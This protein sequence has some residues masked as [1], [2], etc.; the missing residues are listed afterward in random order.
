LPGFEKAYMECLQQESDVNTILTRKEEIVADINRIVGT[1]DHNTQAQCRVLNAVFDLIGQIARAQHTFYLVRADTIK[2]YLRSGGQLPDLEYDKATGQ[3]TYQPAFEFTY[4]QPL[5]EIEL[6]VPIDSGKSFEE[7]IGGFLQILNALKGTEKAG[8][9]LHELTEATLIQRIRPRDANWRWFTDGFADFITHELLKKHLGAGAA[10]DWAGI[11]DIK[12]YDDLQ[13]EINLMYWMNIPYCVTPTLE[14]EQRFSH[15]RY[16]YAMHEAQRLIQAYGLDCVRKILDRVCSQKYQTAQDLFQA[17]KDVTGEDMQDRLCRYQTFTKRE[18]G[19][20]KYDNLLEAAHE[21]GDYEQ[22]L[23]NLTRKLELSPFQFL[24]ASLKIR[25]QVARVLFKLGN[26]K[27]GDQ[28]MLDILERLK[29][30]GIEAIYDYFSE[31]FLDYAMECDKPQKAERIAGEVL[32]KYPRSLPALTVKMRLL[33]DS[34]NLVEAEKVAKK[35]LLLADAGSL[36]NRS[37]LD[38]LRLNQTRKGYASK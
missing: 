9:A 21:Q 15:A 5:K 24:P 8:I 1:D 11:R 6:M 28:T 37:A 36:H 29:Q 2:N 3:M 32:A 35:V 34:G 14:C 23:I 33:T 20:D 16:A 22:M 13:K 7:E 10:A 18:E 31:Q 12:K 26:E 27:A 19:I 30:P 17:I 25:R 38:V 4:S